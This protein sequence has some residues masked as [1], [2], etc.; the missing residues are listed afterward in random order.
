MKEYFLK[1]V[2]GSAGEG[3]GGIVS[4]YLDGLE[5]DKFVEEGPSYE[6][7]YWMV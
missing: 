3:E 7:G 6:G 1:E 4:R 5:V 2:Q